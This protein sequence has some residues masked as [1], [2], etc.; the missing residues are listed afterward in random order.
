MADSLV[1][2]E[3]DEEMLFLVRLALTKEEFDIK[4]VCNGTDG[5]RMV[6]EEI[7]CLVILNKTL[8]D[9]D[10]LEVCKA[11]RSD[12][13]TAQIPIIMLTEKTKEPNGILGLELGADDFIARPF[14][15][16]ELL[17]KVRALLRRAGQK[18]D[19]PIKLIYKS[20]VV[21]TAACE[22]KDG[23]QE[24]ELT[25]KEYMLLVFLVRNRGHVMSR[26]VI[27]ESAWGV[28]KSITTRTVD[29][30]IRNLRKKMPVLSKSIVTIKQF[31][32]KLKDE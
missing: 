19:I 24:L 7:P 26:R 25:P 31:G 30:H 12:L 11:I 22:V 8:P 28:S 6:K 16:M 4:T 13:R 15:S 9:I 14:S 1:I 2:I 23:D 5:L 18:K 27:L 3:D 17:A 32:Y 21:D 20:I 10:G 29:N